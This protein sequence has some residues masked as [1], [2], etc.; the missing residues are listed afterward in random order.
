MIRARVDYFGRPSEPIS[1]WGTTTDGLADATVPTPNRAPDEWDST[2]IASCAEEYVTKFV[3]HRLERT[4]GAGSAQAAPLVVRYEFDEVDGSWTAA[5]AFVERGVGC[6]LEEGSDGL[7]HCPVCDHGLFELADM[8]DA[9]TDVSDF[10]LRAQP[11]CFE[12]KSDLGGMS[13]QVRWAREGRRVLC[14]GCRPEVTAFNL[15]AGGRI[16]DL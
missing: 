8:P 14:R 4:G 10:R 7:L 5:R 6:W 11:G 15:M 13:H 1:L 3:R 9:S 2:A 16:E 12:R